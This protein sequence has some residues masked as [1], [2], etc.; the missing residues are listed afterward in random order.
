MNRPNMLLL[1]LRI[2]VNVRILLTLDP[3]LM[4][5]GICSI[6]PLLIELSCLMMNSCLEEFLA[7]CMHSRMITYMKAMAKK[8]AS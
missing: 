1:I 4:A 3:E 5:E 2:S 6:G 8:G 7:L